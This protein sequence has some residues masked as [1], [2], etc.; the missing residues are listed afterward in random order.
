MS[1]TLAEAEAEARRIVNDWSMGAAAI[2]WVPGSSIYLAYN[3][4]EM[5]ESVARAFGVHEASVEATFSAIAGTV[6]GRTA[7][8]VL[9]SVIPVV[10]W[11][12]KAGVA[13]A[14]TKALGEAIISHYRDRSPYAGAVAIEATPSYTTLNPPSPEVTYEPA[15]APLAPPAPPPQL[16]PSDS[17]QASPIREFTARPRMRVLRRSGN[18]ETVFAEA[19]LG[20]Q[21]RGSFGALQGASSPLTEIEYEWEPISLSLILHIGG[22]SDI[23]LRPD[24]TKSLLKVPRVRSG[25]PAA[26]PIGPGDELYLDGWTFVFA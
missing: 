20:A 1:T 10:G 17:P 26:V 16:P 21:T 25:M 24:Q 6:V 23:Y 15:P 4:Y 12:I 11:A 9:L 13:A 19:T 18:H 3:Q 5:C 2:G 8:D 22:V 7:A 14:T